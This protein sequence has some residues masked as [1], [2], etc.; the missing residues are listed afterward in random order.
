[1]VLGRNLQIF[2]L[3]GVQSRTKGCSQIDKIE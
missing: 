1:M 3:K 2:D